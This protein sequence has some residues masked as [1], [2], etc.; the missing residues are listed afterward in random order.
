MQNF[1]Y[2]VGL[3]NLWGNANKVVAAAAAFFND[4]AFLTRC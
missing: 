3:L 1:L 4:L 2:K